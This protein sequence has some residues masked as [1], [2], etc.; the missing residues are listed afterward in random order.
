MIRTH[1]ELCYI[2]REEADA[3]NLAS[4]ALYT[5][6]MVY[7]WR[8]YR[9]QG[10]WLSGNAAERWNDR[11]NGNTL[12]YAHAADAAQQGFYKACT[13]TRTLRKC[14]IEAKFPHR[15][16]RYRTTVWKQS[17]I[18]VRDG[19]ILLSRARGVE[20]IALPIPESVREAL[21]ILEVR[22]VY[23][24]KSRR[25]FWH[26][27]YE[28][29]KQPKSS[30]GDKVV[31]VDLGEVHPAVVGNEQEATLVTCRERRYEVQGF[32]KR[33]AQISQ[34]QSRKRKGSRAWHRLRNAKNR[35]KAKHQQVMRDLDHKISRIIVDTAVEH[36]AGTIVLGDIRDISNGVNLGKQTNQ[37][38]S[39][40]S[41][42]KVRQYVEYK[43]EAEG[44][45]V[46]TISEA[47]SSQTCPFCGHRHK[48]QG[49]WYTC[50][51][52]GFQAHRDVVGMANI[53]SRYR[54][55]EVGKIPPPE[56]LKQRRPSELRSKGSVWLRGRMRRRPGT[57]QVSKKETCLPVACSQLQEAAGL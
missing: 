33:L 38:V 7:H 14:G 52:C 42:G 47:Y 36:H 15:R 29:G 57:G 26:I 25:Y 18:R 32:N 46:E 9:K 53:L 11:I 48:P 39:N 22:L 1:I 35:L 17:G 19:E 3:L 55:G 4:G 49:R 6:V 5:Q 45:K 27:V 24:K 44:I 51:S 13:T 21:R 10:V 2:P 34:A 12:L 30:P 56:Q 16:K 31:A 40:W 43:A 8:V 37:K 50:P 41:H 20:P 54:H 23:C 28:N